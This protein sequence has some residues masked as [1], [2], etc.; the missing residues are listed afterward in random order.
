MSANS[1]Y[2]LEIGHRGKDKD[3]K[4]KYE[5]S[6]GINSRS[7]LYATHY[8]LPPAQE[9]VNLIRLDSV[10]PHTHYPCEASNLS[11]ETS[12]DQK[13]RRRTVDATRQE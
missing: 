13:V 6:M 12:Q 11:S 9:L 5:R 7:G 10:H 3:R 2:V 4:K 1:D 8:A